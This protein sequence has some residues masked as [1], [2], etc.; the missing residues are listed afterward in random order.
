MMVLR[1]SL[2]IVIHVDPT[3]LR[4]ATGFDLLLWLPKQGG[5]FDGV[6]EI[7]ASTFR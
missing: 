7:W 1:P 2:T 6:A 4:L 5:V 3:P